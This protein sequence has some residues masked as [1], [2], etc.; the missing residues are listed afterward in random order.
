MPLLHVTDMS[1]NFGGLQAVADY[2]LSLDPGQIT[3]LIGPNG[4]GKTT[5]FNLITGIYRPTHGSVM[6]DGREI[7]GKKP[8]ETA[9]MGLARTFQEM[10]LW[11]HMT[12]LEHIKMARYSKFSYG[13]MGAFLDTPRRRREEREATDLA[14]EYLK[15][16]GVEQ[17]ADQLVI[18][19]PYG[20]QRRV[21]M[22]R[23]MVIEPK[24]LLLDEPTVGM[25]PDEMLAMIEVVRSAH[26][27]FNLAIFLIEHRLRVVHELCQHVQALVFGRVLVEGTPAEVQNHPEV[28]KAYI[29]EQ[30]VEF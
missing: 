4:A 21:E 19:L 11:R 6:F 12:V 18:N 14:M 25:T 20:A 24:V 26:E 13:L 30:E 7:T 1:H 2:H 5:I 3:G 15:M 17:F 27:R 10:K 8:N 22:A 23:A 28:I 9:A 16:F 29:G